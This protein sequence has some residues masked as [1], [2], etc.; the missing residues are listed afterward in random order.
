MRSSSLGAWIIALAALA[1]AIVSAANYLTPESGIAMTPGALLVVGSTIILL[2][3]GLWLASRPRSRGLRVILVILSFLDIIG[4]AFAGWL[5]ESN[6]LLIAMAVALIGWL[7]LLFSPARAVTTTP[8]A[9]R[10]RP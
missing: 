9:G 4:T 6:A 8:V 5:L 2:I 3:F 1:G 7:I 10:A